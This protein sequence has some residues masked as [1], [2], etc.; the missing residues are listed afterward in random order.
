MKKPKLLK[1]KSSEIREAMSKKWCAPEYAT[2]WEVAE[3]TGAAG[4]RYADAVI[5]SLWPSRGLELHGVEIKVSRSDW[6][7]E[8]ADP[9]KAE[10]IGK[11]CDRWYVHTPKGL[12]VDLSEVP[13]AWGLREYD[14]SRWVTVREAEK[15][16]AA[17]MT[18]PFL[19]AM[20]RRADTLMAKM[21]QDAVKA[22]RDAEVKDYAERRAQ[23]RREVEA[24]ADR[25]LREFNKK[26]E[27][28]RAFEAAFGE[29]LLSSYQDFG[30]IGRAARIL[31]EASS[32]GQWTNLETLERR[33]RGS[34][35]AIKEAIETFDG[36]ASDMGG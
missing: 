14:G 4:G 19:A 16:E 12:V 3:G 7:R 27:A 1:M 35:D 5:M 32:C 21:I 25:K 6:K 11:Y 30:A 13:P 36:I 24:A 33:L 34:A 9:R 22:A 29:D 31:A 23:F 17:A 2:M 18:R 20:L 15:T 28:Y 10:A 26:A 8:A